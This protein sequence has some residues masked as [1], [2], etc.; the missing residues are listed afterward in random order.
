MTSECMNE[1][2]NEAYYRGELVQKSLS[3]VQPSWQVGGPHFV[4]NV[5]KK[6][7]FILLNDFVSYVHL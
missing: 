5:N 1:K 6:R 2:G 3:E 7:M 4:R